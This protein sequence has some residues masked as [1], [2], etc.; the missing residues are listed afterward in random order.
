MIIDHAISK[1]QTF[2]LLDDNIIVNI[3]YGKS[4]HKFNV[5]CVLDILIFKMLIYL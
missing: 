3:S 2:V 5:G 4:A 1:V